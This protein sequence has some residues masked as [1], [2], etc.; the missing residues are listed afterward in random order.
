MQVGLAQRNPAK[1]DLPHPLLNRR[2]FENHDAT[3]ETGHIRHGR[4]VEPARNVTPY[5]IR[6]MSPRTMIRGPLHDRG[7]RLA[8]PTLCSRRLRRTG[9]SFVAGYCGGRALLPE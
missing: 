7:F 1:N 2:G 4:L 9:P 6:R 5:L 8:L 3:K